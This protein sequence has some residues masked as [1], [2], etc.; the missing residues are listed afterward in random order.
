MEIIEGNGETWLL[1]NYPSSPNGIEANSPWGR[2][3]YRLLAH[4]GERDNCF[5]KIIQ[6]GQKSEVENLFLKL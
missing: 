6:I 5:S 1:N 3:G 2:M 4:E